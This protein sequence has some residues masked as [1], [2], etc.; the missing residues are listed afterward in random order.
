MGN[1]MDRA[2]KRRLSGG[3]E[4]SEFGGPL[5]FTEL[6]GTSNLMEYWDYHGSFTTPPCTEVVD[7]YVMMELGMLTQ[8]QLN[9]FKTAIGWAAAQGNYRPPQ[10]LGQRAVSGCAQVA[11][12]PYKPQQWASQ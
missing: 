5:D 11:W 1:P 6:Y 7:F 4:Y 10:P 3:V 8:A 9:K 2:T 12:Y